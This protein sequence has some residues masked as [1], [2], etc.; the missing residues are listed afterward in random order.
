M[1]CQSNL[2]DSL[3]F[4]V[5]RRREVKT[6]G[7][8]RRAGRNADLYDLCHCPTRS[9][10]TAREIGESIFLSYFWIPPAFAGL[11]AVYSGVYWMCGNDKR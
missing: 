5:R 3:I 10:A 9:P 1:K 4:S 2:L 8:A 11:R 6:V 7:T